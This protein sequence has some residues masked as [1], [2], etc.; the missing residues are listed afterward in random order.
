MA[1]I[2]VYLTSYKSKGNVAPVYLSLFVGGKKLYFNTKVFCS[3]EKWDEIKGKIKGNSKKVKDDNLIIQSCVNRIHEIQVK[4]RLLNKELTQELLKTEYKNPS[5][6]ID[7]LKFLEESI[8]ERRG[9]VTDSTIKQH[10]VLITKLRQFQSSIAFSEITPDFLV[11]FQRFMKVELKNDIS[12]IFN[13]MKNLRTY[14]NIAIRKELLDKSPFPGLKIKR[15]DNKDRVFLSQEELDKLWSLYE[16]EK[17]V[18]PEGYY[19]YLR[20]FLFMCYTGLRVSDLKVVT[21]NNIITNF[22]VYSP[23]KTKTQKKITIKLPLVK[24]AVKLIEDENNQ[25]SDLLF[26]CCSE[27]KMNMK[28]KD[29]MPVI[30]IKKKVTNHTARHTFATLFLQKTHD[31]AA[32]QKLLGHSKITDTMKYVH[33]TDNHISDMMDLFEE[34]I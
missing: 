11:K 18:L 16:K 20:W 5:Y 6:G 15:G 17:R 33:I 10:K 27:Q 24:K 19:S 1:Q 30:G 31:V 22:L 2:K 25:E 3:P 13:T 32:L 14:I 21:Y 26:K 23:Q 12:T 29:I 7:F 4:Y 28:I 9:E 8:L 34:T